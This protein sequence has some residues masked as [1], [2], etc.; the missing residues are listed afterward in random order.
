M[1]SKKSPAIRLALPNKGQ[2]LDPTLSFLAAC[3]L[4]IYKPNERQYVASVPALP[5]VSILFQRASDIVA[6]VDEGSADLGITGYDIVCEEGEAHDD[7]LV[8]WENLGYGKCELVLAVPESWIDVSSIG[9]LAELS[10]SYKEK[11]RPLRIATKFPNLTRDWL[12][13]RGII[14]FSL[15]EAEGALEAAPSIG[16]ADMI[17]DLTASGTTLKENRLK[18][19][20][21]GTI[22]QSQAC[23]IGNRRLLAGHPEKLQTTRIMLELIEAHVRAKQYVTVAG[24]FRAPSEEALAGRLLAAP[25]MLG[26]RGPRIARVYTPAAGESDWYAVSIVVEKKLLLPAVDHLRSVGGTDITVSPP[27]YLF[28]ATSQRFD[29]LLAK[30]KKRDE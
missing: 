12:Y 26:L 6:K 28:D 14:H 17:A 18:R 1:L 8:I 7:V 20:A 3:G 21:G 5:Q 16:Y 30:L 29:E 2:L 4:E 11:G 24:N 15:I 22:L 9:D 23:L 25:E 27:T 10:V 19:I 13:E